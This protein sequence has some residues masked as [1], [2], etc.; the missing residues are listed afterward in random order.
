VRPDFTNIDN[1]PSSVSTVAAGNTAETTLNAA[2]G[3]DSELVSPWFTDQIPPFDVT[4]AAANEY[5]SLAVM[6]IYGVELLNEGYG[7]SV[8]DIVSE[9]QH[10]YIARTIVPWKSAGSVPGSY[11]SP[12]T[13]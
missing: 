2:D 6:R 13:K 7:V 3:Y 12:S 9:Q 5:G 11:V 8:D 4:L 1:A 10:T